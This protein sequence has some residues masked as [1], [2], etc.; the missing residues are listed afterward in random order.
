MEIVGRE[1]I[2]DDDI[3]HLTIH[4]AVL[5]AQCIMSKVNNYFLIFL[6]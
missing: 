3:I 2:L 4:D 1:T 5:R 6:L